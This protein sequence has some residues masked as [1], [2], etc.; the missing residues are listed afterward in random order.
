MP[1]QETSA[2][3]KIRVLAARILT[4]RSISGHR[5][6]SLLDSAV[7]IRLNDLCQPVGTVC[8]TNQA[9]NFAKEENQMSFVI[10]ETAAGKIVEVQVTGKLSKQAY[11]Q[12]VPMTEAK[13]KYFDHSEIEAAREWIKQ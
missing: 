9:V 12:F 8:A 13:I 2:W 6:K 3:S 10:T 7:K 11:E 4:N 5:D 1:G